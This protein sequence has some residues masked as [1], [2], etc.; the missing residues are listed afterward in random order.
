VHGRARRLRHT[1]GA[2][3]HASQ[4]S[5]QPVARHAIV[6]QG[7]PQPV[8]ATHVHQP[9][10]LAVYDL[11]HLP[12]VRPHSPNHACCTDMPL[13]TYSSKLVNR[14]C[15]LQG[16]SVLSQLSAWI[17]TGLVPCAETD[18]TSRGSATIAYLGSSNYSV[19]AAV[20]SPGVYLVQLTLR[21]TA[22]V[23]ET[24]SPS[25]N[26]TV[27]CARGEYFSDNEACLACPNH[28]STPS[29]FESVVPDDVRTAIARGCL[30]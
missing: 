30:Q 7:E 10:Y 16:H 2:A 11:D 26:L 6:A 5:A 27:N 19:S 25:V 4:L 14:P 24:L 21:T 15:R 8:R 3:Q 17:C 12:L 18:A 23:S 13:C 29:A 28:A 1:A 9:A 20:E 22:G